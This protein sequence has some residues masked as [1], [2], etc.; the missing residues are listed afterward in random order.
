MEEAAHGPH[1]PDLIEQHADFHPTASGCDEGIPH[2]AP[3]AVHAPDVEFQMQVMPG[4]PDQP[5]KFREESRAIH[6]QDRF[7]AAA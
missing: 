2:D 7:I 5:Q 4:F 6:Q 3:G 1:R